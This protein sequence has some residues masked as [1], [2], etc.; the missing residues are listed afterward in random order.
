MKFSLGIYK[1]L[2][3]LLLALF[4]IIIVNIHPGATSSV[5]L[6]QEPV[7]LEKKQVIENSFNDKYQLYFHLKVDG[8]TYPVQVSSGLFNKHIEGDTVSNF[9]I[10][11]TVYK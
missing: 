11:K 8:A 10:L 4:V 3:G 2:L 5:S 7:I 9:F 1:F 6:T